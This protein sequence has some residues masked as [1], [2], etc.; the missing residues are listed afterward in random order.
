[1]NVR[2]R[3]DGDQAHLRPEDEKGGLRNEQRDGKHV[4]L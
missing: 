2:Q 1:M 3:G 4:W